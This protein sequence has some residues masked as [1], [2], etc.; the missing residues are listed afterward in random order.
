MIALY[1][2]AQR[3]QEFCLARE[4]NFCFIGGLAVLRWGQIRVTKDVDMTLLTGFGS[5]ENFVDQITANFKFRPVCN[6]EFALRNRVLFQDE[7]G[8][9]VDIAL[10]AIP[11]EQR[12]IQRSTLWEADS[13][14]FLRTCSAEDLLVYKRFANRDLDWADVEN[15]LARQTNNLDLAQVRAELKPLA[16]LKPE[17]PIL[18]SLERR[19]RRQSEPF[20]RIKPT[21]GQ[22]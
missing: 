22:P 18:E 9:A 10:G 11:F 16:E 19:I 8:V 5:E 14:L 7:T 3:L 20:T 4:W 17:A 13:N 15:I 12:S 6:R 2:T 21:S 1:R